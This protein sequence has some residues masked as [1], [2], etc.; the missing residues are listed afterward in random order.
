MFNEG[1]DPRQYDRFPIANHEG[2]Q[3]CCNMGSVFAVM[4]MSILPSYINEDYE[5]NEVV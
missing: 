5:Y 3:S 1:I 2:S 4:A